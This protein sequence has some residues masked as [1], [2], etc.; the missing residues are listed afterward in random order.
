M[1][2]FEFSQSLLNSIEYVRIVC[3][4][5]LEYVYCMLRFSFGQCKS[6]AGFFPPKGNVEII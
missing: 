6:S 2:A 1:D 5:I 4:F 3:H